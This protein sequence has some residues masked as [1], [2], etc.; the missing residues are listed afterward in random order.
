MRDLLDY[1]PDVPPV[2][3]IPYP[4][5]FRLWPGRTGTRHPD[6]SLDADA[7]PQPALTK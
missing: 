5:G 1:E 7:R 6:D 2:P 4:E 3:A